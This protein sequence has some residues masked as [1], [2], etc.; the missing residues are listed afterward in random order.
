MW[1]PETAVDL[2]TLRLLAEH[3]IEHTILAPWQAAGH[4]LETADPRSSRRERTIVV[5]FTTAG[6]R[7]G[8]FELGDTT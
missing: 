1:L 2:A 5:V 3:G 7:G 6:C 4:H 8:L